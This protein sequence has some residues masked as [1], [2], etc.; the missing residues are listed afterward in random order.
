MT[1][2]DI[3]FALSNVAKF[4]LKLTK[5]HWTAVKRIFRYL[6]GTQKYGL[7]YNRMQEKQPIIG[8]SDLDWAGDLNDHKS[9]S[10]YIF[11]VGGTAI[12]WRSKKQTC[13]AQSTAQAEYIALSQAG[14]EVV[15]PPRPNPCGRR[16]WYN[17]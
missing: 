6:K 9:T 5:E 15:W 8:Y 13:M 10:G 14:Q 4:N 12:S 16:V 2:P 3:T 11:T 1:R 17:A 7:L